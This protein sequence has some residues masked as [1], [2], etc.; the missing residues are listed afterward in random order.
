[1]HGAYKVLAHD[2]DQDGDLD[3]AAISFFPDYLKSP[4]KSFVYLSNEGEFSFQ[5]YSFPEAT[6]GRWIVMD[7]GDLEGDGDIDIALGSFV[8]F[9]PEGDTTEL[10]DQWLK[11]S[12]SVILL[13][14]TIQ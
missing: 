4:E 10:Y 12:P 1:M 7:A 8:D 14:N 3:I 9:A 6:R 2:Y 5:V 11:N 13:E